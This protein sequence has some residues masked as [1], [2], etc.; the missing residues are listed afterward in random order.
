MKILALTGI[1]LGILLAAGCEKLF[2]LKEPQALELDTFWKVNG[3][4]ANE[5]EIYELFYPPLPCL[6]GDKIVK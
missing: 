3:S 2:G 1:I 4:Y 5:G 6:V